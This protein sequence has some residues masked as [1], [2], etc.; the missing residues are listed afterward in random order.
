L[1]SAAAFKLGNESGRLNP[2]PSLIFL[3]FIEKIPLL[4]NKKGLCVCAGAFSEV[5]EIGHF[6]A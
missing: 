2:L 4:I 1:V 3:V 6:G 5:E